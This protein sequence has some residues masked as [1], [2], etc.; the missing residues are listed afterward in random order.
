MQRRPGVKAEETNRRA[1]AVGLVGVGAR[2]REARRESKGHAP[3]A[4]VP[5]ALKVPAQLAGTVEVGSSH[6]MQG[7]YRSNLTADRKLAR[8]TSRV[9][10]VV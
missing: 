9:R 1:E 5:C 7:A 10:P 2:L 3:V 6:K 8:H 4:D